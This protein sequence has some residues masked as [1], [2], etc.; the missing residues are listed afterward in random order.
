MVAFSHP[1]GYLMT[2]H[3]WHLYFDMQET[4]ALWFFHFLQSLSPLGWKVDPGPCR[5]CCELPSPSAAIVLAC[6]PPMPSSANKFKLFSS[7][8]SGDHS[9]LTLQPVPWTSPA[10]SSIITSLL[11]FNLSSSSDVFLLS[12]KS[13]HSAP[14]DK[15]SPK[16][17]SIILHL[18]SPTIISSC[19]R[20]LRISYTLSNSLNSGLT[21]PWKL[22]SLNSLF[23]VT[24][25]C[26]KSQITPKPSDIKQ[27]FYYAVHSESQGVKLVIRESL[28]LLHDDDQKPIHGLSM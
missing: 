4:P 5:W 23:Q 18:S 24:L 12:Y 7:N 19:V 22:L 26:N 8:L 13:F 1:F 15:N 10:N 3:P 25:L 9:S 21:P 11:Y 2:S 6:Y 16:L 14:S 17:P 20:P 27:P 28:F